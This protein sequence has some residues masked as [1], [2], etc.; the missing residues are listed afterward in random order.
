MYYSHIYFL[1]R[2]FNNLYF[3][4]YVCDLIFYRTT[5][6]LS[7]CFYVVRIKILTVFLILLIGIYPVRKSYALSGSDHGFIENKG[8]IV[9]QH[10]K[11]NPEVLYLLNNPGLNVQLRKTGFS[12]DVYSIEYKLNPNHLILNDP[13]PFSRVHQ[14]DSLIPVYNFHRIDITLAGANPHCQIIPSDPLPDY[15][16]YFTAAA[17]AEG[18]K[19]VRQYSKITYQ[20]IYPDIDLEFFTNLEHGYKY[21]FV[22][23][24]GADINDIR[25]RIEGEDHI[26]LIND[27]LKFGTRFGD[28]DELIPESYYLINSSRVD[29]QVRFKQIEN[30]IFGFSL[31]EKIPEN[32]LLVI[33]PTSIRLW[34][35]YYGGSGWEGGNGCSVD[36]TENVF[37]SGTTNSPNNIA[38]GGAYQGSLAGSYDG[39]LAKFNAAGQRQWGTYFGGPAMDEGVSCVIDISDNIYVSGDTQSTSGIASAGAH[40]TVYGGGSYDCYIEKFNQAGNRIWGTY[41]GGSGLDEGGFVTTD[42]NGNVFLP[43]TTSSDTG[44]ATP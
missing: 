9:D 33:D 19:N 6:C 23:H 2:K 30:E 3:G 17:P 42:K 1:S 36:K 18:I 16:N 43:G 27:T 11:S 35:T 34:G 28:V 38:S 29:L 8:Q 31:N 7:G 39:F 21:N 37:L 22:I 13:N 40:Q 32:A 24:P 14:S 44:I 26:S 15:F 25:L 5:L 10:Y 20:N 12:Y 4:L 41:Y